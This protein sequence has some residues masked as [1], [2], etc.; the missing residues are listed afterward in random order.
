MI[1]KKV[2]LGSA[3]AWVLLL[4]SFFYQLE[5][6]QSLNFGHYFWLVAGAIFV[7]WTGKRYFY[8]PPVADQS[9][10]ERYA[11]AHRIERISQSW[12]AFGS[13]RRYSRC[14]RE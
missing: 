3:V 14:N 10:L 5:P 4:I 8:P 7:V 9:Y 13:F 1:W 12:N 11:K 6:G 2:M